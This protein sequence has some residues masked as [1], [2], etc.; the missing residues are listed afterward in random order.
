[1]AGSNYQLI[2]LNSFKDVCERLVLWKE[3][4]WFLETIV[5]GFYHLES[6]PVDSGLR[7]SG[8]LPSQLSLLAALLPMADI[9]SEESDLDDLLYLTI[10]KVL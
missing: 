10:S 3:H 2:A 5:E 8:H 4:P 6:Q 1:M 7:P 9:L